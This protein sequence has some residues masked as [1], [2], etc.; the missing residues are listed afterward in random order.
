MSPFIEFEA[1]NV[2]RA[3]TKACEALKIPRDQ[4]KHEVL[5]FGATGIFGL[6]GIKKARI[7]VAAP[8]IQKSG[9]APCSGE[10]STLPAG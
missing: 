5:S 9:A 2:E 4:L 7:R 10:N 1:K 8:G 3:V 6:V